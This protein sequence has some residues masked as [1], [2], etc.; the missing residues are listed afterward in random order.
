MPTP[1]LRLYA[2]SVDNSRCHPDKFPGVDHEKE[3]KSRLVMVIAA[4]CLHG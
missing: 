1:D 4:P 2:G 3:K